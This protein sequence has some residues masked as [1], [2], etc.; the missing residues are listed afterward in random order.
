MGR[1][2]ALDLGEKRVGLAVSDPLGW[3]AQGLPTLARPDTDAEHGALDRLIRDH[4]VER[5]VVGLPL[6]LDGSEGQ[7][8]RAARA[9]ADALA[10]RFGLPVELWDERLTTAEADH[11]MRLAGVRR[12]RRQQASD[13]LAATLLLQSWLDARRGPA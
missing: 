1:V 3:T 5:L 2:L 12:R 7:A 9:A 13:R 10:L 4:D 8:A 11:V 6:R